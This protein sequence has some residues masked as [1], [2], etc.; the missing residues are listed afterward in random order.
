[1][2]RSEVD[3]VLHSK[4]GDGRVGEINKGNDVNRKSALLYFRSGSGL[5]VRLRNKKEERKEKQNDVPRPNYNHFNCLPFFGERR[6][7]ES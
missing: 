3:S 1:M 4:K 2:Y 7:S 6:T 5:K